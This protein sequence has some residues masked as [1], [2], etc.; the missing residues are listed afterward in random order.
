[1]TPEPFSPRKL[2]A[3]VYVPSVLHAMGFGML[4]P[5][6]PLFAQEL[7]VPLVLIGSLV[8]VRGLG[9]MLTDLPAGFVTARLA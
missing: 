2:A 4:A 3:G 7:D 8:A 1:M 5:A 9:G 6:I